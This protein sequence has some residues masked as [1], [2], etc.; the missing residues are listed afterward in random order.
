MTQLADGNLNAFGACRRPLVEGE[1]ELDGGKRR[2]ETKVRN[3]IF[4]RGEAVNKRPD[5]RG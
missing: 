4:P 1:S 5:S 3:N 2:V